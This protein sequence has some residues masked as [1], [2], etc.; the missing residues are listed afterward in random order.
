MRELPRR[1]L[2]LIG[3]AA[4]VGCTT[5]RS[6][7]E[8]SGPP[9]TVTDT[10]T[11]RPKRRFY[12]VRRFGVVGDGSAD[13]A[14]PLHEALNWTAARGAGLLIPADVRLGLS[15]TVTLPSRAHLTGAG[16][17][18]PLDRLGVLLAV[19]EGAED[20]VI[21]G[22][23][24]GGSEARANVLIS[25][26]GAVRPRV[27]SCDVGDAATGV[28]LRSGT[29]SPTVTRCSFARLDVGVHVRG[30]VEGALIERSRFEAWRERAIWVVGL[31][32][33]APTR[34]TIGSNVISPPAP[35]GRVRQPIQ[36]NGDD[37]RPLTDVVVTGNRVTGAGTSYADPT[38][39]GTADLISLH[40]CVRFSVTKNVVTDGGDVGITVSRQSRNGTVADNTAL[41]NDSVGI[42]IGSLA[43]D[44]V[45]DIV[46]SGNV[47][48]DNGQNRAS[49]GVPWARAGIEV[50]RGTNVTLEGNTVRDGGAGTQVN[51]ISIIDSPSVHVTGNRITA[52]GEKIR[53]QSSRVTGHTP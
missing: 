36:I 15:R 51:G 35:G 44:G 23:R 13:D 11:D 34:L 12:S 3:M 41:R 17:I 39:P 21:S 49:D 26:S 38:L 29:R 6:R 19:P 8:E 22:L 14:G 50:A 20:C 28:D 40:R 45:W 2:P 16:R 18:A 5:S 31:E 46:A 30:D 52:T 7:S 53:V 4:L 27:E 24:L 43:S 37:K 33:E 48:T 1:A 42:C 9:S 25:I 32:E 10:P 47:C